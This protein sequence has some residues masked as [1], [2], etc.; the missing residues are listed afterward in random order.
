MS[1]HRKLSHSEF[2]N[3]LENIASKAT[4]DP[5]V[6]GLTPEIVTA[7][8]NSRG[9]IT[10]GIADNIAK[11]D[12]ARAATTV[13]LSKRKTGDDLVSHIKATMRL[14]RMPSEKFHELGLDGDDPSNTPAAPQTPLDLLAEGFSGGNNRLKFR[15]NGNRP[16]TIFIVE[17][18]IGAAETFSIVGTTTKTTFLHKNQTPGVKIVYRVRAQRNDEFSDYSNSAI[19]YG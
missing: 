7:V 11:K 6:F 1:D 5:S 8:T 10:N 2:K 19:V 14:A 4:G 17:A 9:E 13:L 15:R 18:K 3:L 12:A 16:Q